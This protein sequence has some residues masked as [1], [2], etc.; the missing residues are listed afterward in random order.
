MELLRLHDALC[1]LRAAEEQ[2]AHRQTVKCPGGDNQKKGRRG[3]KECGW[4]DGMEEDFRS[5]AV[6]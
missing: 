4:P 2:R 6:P 3:V 1:L 5:K